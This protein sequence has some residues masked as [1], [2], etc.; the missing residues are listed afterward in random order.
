MQRGGRRPREPRRGRLPRLGVD[1]GRADPG[2]PLRP[3][4]RALQGHGRGCGPAPADQR[5]KRAADRG[6]AGEAAALAADPHPARRLGE[7]P[8]LLRLRRLPEQAA[9]DEDVPHRCR[10]PPAA[11]GLPRG[12]EHAAGAVREA[13]P[14][15]LDSIVIRRHHLG[16]VHPPGLALESSD[17]Q[18][19]DPTTNADRG[20]SGH[21]TRR[22][23]RDWKAIDFARMALAAPPTREYSRCC[24]RARSSA[25]WGDIPSA[26]CESASP[27]RASY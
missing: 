20:V 4:E 8:A 24:G 1:P 7:P 25:R 11:R 14:A 17:R 16:S 19:N 26:E 27:S 10:L 9:R 23:Y 13:V 12:G 15:G 18:Q 21:V 22:K 5:A 2:R 3:Q 6:D